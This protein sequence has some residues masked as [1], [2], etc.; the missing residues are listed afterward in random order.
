MKKNL[1][2][3][4]VKVIKQNEN[5]VRDTVDKKKCDHFWI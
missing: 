5:L 4:V 3:E 2:K 1:A